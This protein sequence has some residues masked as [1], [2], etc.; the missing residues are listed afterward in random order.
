LGVK[1]H[2]LTDWPWALNQ[3]PDTNN[4]SR[5]RL[6]GAAG[7]VIGSLMSMPGLLAGPSLDPSV[8]SAV[9]WR[10]A[11]GDALYMAAWDHK[12]PGAY[13]VVSLAHLLTRGPEAAWIFTWAASVLATAL[14]AVIVCLVL[15]RHAI[16]WPAAAGGILVAVVLASYPLTLG[17]G[18]GESFAILPAIAA[19][20]TVSGSNTRERNWL[21]VGALLGLT[22]LISV[23]AASVAGALVV[24]G[25]SGEWRRVLGR[26]AVATSG[27]AVVAGVTVLYLVASG[28]WPAAFDAVVG[29][30]AAYRAIGGS[31]PD[32][33]LLPLFIL[34]IGPVLLPAIASI[35]LLREPRMRRLVVACLLWVAA[36]VAG[37][38]VEQRIYGHYLLAV[39]PALG[40]LAGLGIEALRR[41]WSSVRWG[42]PVLLGGLASAALLSLSVG[43]LVARDQQAGTAAANERSA[44]VASRIQ[45]MTHSG[46]TIFVWGNAPGVYELG[47]RDP[48]TRYLIL[49]PLITQGYMTRREIGAIRTQLAE[50]PPALFVDA[51][52]TRPGEPGLP[53][54][55]IERPVSSD[56]RDLDILDP[57]RD[58]V[59][60]N[61]VA[62]GVIDGWPVYRY[63]PLE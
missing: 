42:R 30:N 17:G 11:S 5:K 60:A 6:V 40:I 61:Y 22:A 23:Q 43:G 41:R 33:S 20:A 52:S 18:L 9:A 57:L 63:A 47:V 15:V 28:A 56:G 38:A 14:V 36:F 3:K 7:L 55:L 21:T 29:Y 25:W 44:A 2:H 34:I 19:V 26:T 49:F 16:A 37:L 35:L 39:V 58:F 54:L 13:L 4:D 27:L 10:L 53:P 8:F 24:L 45:E 32:T 51:G 48:A 31:A 46:D 59:R 62:A 1:P 50:H 12:P